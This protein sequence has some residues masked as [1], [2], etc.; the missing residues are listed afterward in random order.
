LRFA[1]FRHRQGSANKSGMEFRN[2]PPRIFHLDNKFF[3]ERS[4]FFV[5]WMMWE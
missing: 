4:V 1:I 3:V 2:G 5:A